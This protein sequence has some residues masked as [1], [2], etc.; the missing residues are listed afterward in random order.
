M[1]RV[2]A[3]LA[4]VL[5]C[6]IGRTEVSP[7]L[8]PGP[9]PSSHADRLR[10]AI[11]LAGAGDSAVSPSA[12][13]FA[14]SDRVPDRDENDNEN[15]FREVSEPPRMLEPLQ[16]LISR[17]VPRLLPSIRSSIAPSWRTPLLC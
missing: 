10:S 4:L 5:V 15:D 11:S 14:P 1:T 8:A 2:L 7:T 9:G 16:A 17:T 6:N 13:L 12:H 3:L